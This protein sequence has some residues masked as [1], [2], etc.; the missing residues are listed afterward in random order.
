MKFTHQNI[1]GI[2]IFRFLE[3]KLDTSNS[4]LLKGEFS[5]FVKSEKVTKLVI[6]LTEIEHCD[7]SGL[8]TLL[9]VNRIMQ[10]KEGILRLVPSSKILQLCQITKLDRVLSIASTIDEAVLELRKIEA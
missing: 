10:E 9:V 1:D 5:S 7:S 8:S 3:R 2:F 6:D 4:G